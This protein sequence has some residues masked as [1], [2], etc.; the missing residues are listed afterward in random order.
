M[1]QKKVGTGLVS[2]PDKRIAISN[3]SDSFVWRTH[4]TIYPDPDVSAFA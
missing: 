2:P 3:D 1:S 4:V